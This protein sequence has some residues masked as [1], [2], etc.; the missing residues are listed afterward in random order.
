MMNVGG[1]IIKNKESSQIMTLIPV[2]NNIEI[3]K[4]PTDKRNSQ[5][6]VSLERCKL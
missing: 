3:Y 5:A 1:G 6:S 4:R 2:K